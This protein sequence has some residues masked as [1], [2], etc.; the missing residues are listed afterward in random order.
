MP[1][2]ARSRA[3][4]ERLLEAA[5]VEFAESGYDGATTAAIADRA[6]VPIGTLYQ[7]F[8]DKAAIFDTLAEG[9]LERIRDVWEQQILPEAARRSL[10]ELLEYAVTAHAEFFA[11]EPAFAAVWLTPRVSPQMILAS[12]QLHEELTARSTEL[13]ARYGVPR[14]AARRGRVA[15]VIVEMIS[16]ISLLSLERED[17]RLM[18]E[19]KLALTAYAK[20]LS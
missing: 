8:P 7:F 17:P 15:A 16:W 10:D 1:V 14:S 5:T 13:L 19:L 4:V 3:R 6:G 20:T 18:A 9:Y 12:T 2:Q 11:R